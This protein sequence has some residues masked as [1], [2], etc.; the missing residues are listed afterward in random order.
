MPHF[1]F[2]VIY[3]VPSLGKSIDFVTLGF[4]NLKYKFDWTMFTSLL[5]AG[6]LHISLRKILPLQ[7]AY[8]FGQR[9][10]IQLICAFKF[11]YVDKSMAIENFCFRFITPALV[12]LADLIPLIKI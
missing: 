4:T 3:R 10:L 7:M 6:A 2:I 5:K 12:P 9:K 11:Q 8:L 1:L